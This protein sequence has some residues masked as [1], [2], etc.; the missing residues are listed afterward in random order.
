[1][2]AGEVLLVVAV[3]LVPAAILWGVYLVR[4]GRPGKP[5]VLLGIPR[6][7]RPGQPD[8]ALEG[9][10]LERIMVWWVL[11]I[12]GLAVFIPA[13]WLG[14]FERQS[15]FE[16]RFS[17]ESVERGRL[18]FAVP[19][20]LPED[21]DPVRFRAVER[22][23]SLG[24]GCAQCHGAPQAE[25]DGE[26]QPVTE[27]TAAGGQ[28]EFTPPGVTK[29]VL[30]RAPPLNNVFT[31]WDEEVVR[32]TI[33]RG[34]PGTDMPAWGVEYGGP[35]TEQMIDDVMAWLKTLP[36]NQQPPGGISDDCANPDKSQYRSCG[37]EIFAAR[38][39]VCHGPE[40]QGKESEPWYQGMALWKGDVRHLNRQQHFTTILNGR[41][42]AFMPAF[43][44][45]P[46]QGIPA[47]PYPLT[48][49][50]INA[51]MAYERTL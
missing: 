23:I 51:V 39:A 44:E 19:P 38:C 18:I 25:I 45:S 11:A 37:Q 4:S 34:R 27:D 30:Y 43:G 14:E 36:G 24:M 42:F 15:H 33:E 29:R 47:P 22:E 8:E 46:S 49:K 17:E 41:R 20:P 1:V 6:A 50:Q 12:L 35:M 26:L 5:A 40:G 21:A 13:Y 28:F 7:L 9:P 16:E 32:F 10:R 2:D 3:V 48:N 31:R